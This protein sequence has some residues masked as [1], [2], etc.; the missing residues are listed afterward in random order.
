MYLKNRQSHN[1]GA[2]SNLAIMLLRSKILTP[3]TINAIKLKLTTRAETDKARNH[4]VKL[5]A[6]I[7]KD[8]E[9]ALLDSEN[10]VN[11]QTIVEKPSHVRITDN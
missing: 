7:V 4:T 5:D 3:D 6:N 1:N 8:I 2:I 11:I 9:T 10:G